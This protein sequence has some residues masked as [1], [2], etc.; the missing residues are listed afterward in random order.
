MEDPTF[1]IFSGRSRKDGRWLEAVQGLSNARERVWQ[2]AE[3]KP[4]SYFI[5]SKRDGAILIKIETFEK[6]QSVEKTIAAKARK[7]HA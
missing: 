3:E 7:A 2:I 4:G 1:D 5:F 6:S